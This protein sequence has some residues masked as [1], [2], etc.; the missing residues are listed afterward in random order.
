MLL[1]KS[2]H[3]ISLLA[4]GF[5][6][7]K[8]HGFLDNKKTIGYRTVSKAEAELINDDDNDNKLRK[9]ENS[10]SALR[11]NPLG[12]GIYIGDQGDWYCVVK[13]DSS[14]IDQISKVWIPEFW[15]KTDQFGEPIG[16][17]ELYGN[18][19]LTVGYIKTVVPEPEKALR[20]SNVG[21]NGELQMLIPTKVVDNN[22]LEL[23]SKCYET[24]EELR[25]VSDGDANWKGWGIEGDLQSANTS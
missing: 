25:E 13:A 3:P 10:D 4:L 15:Q 17:E 23:W 16:Q 5:L 19:D 24:E 6:F 9:D 21:L 7:S 8:A 12:Y 14:K 20:F 22:D 1:S 18:E 2:I 11:L